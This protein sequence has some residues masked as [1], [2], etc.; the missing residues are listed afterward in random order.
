MK[1]LLKILLA[2]LGVLL[3]LLVM[4]AALTQTRRFR[5]WLRDRIVELSRQKLNGR[6]TL[7]RLEGNLISH[8]E[9]FDLKIEREHET[10]LH[11]P[12]IEFGF[13]AA[14]LWHRRIWINQLIIDRPVIFLRQRPDSSWNVQDLIV[15]DTTAIWPVV[16]P[17]IRI[18]EAE[19][20]VAPRDSTSFFFQRRVQQLN[21]TL[22][23]EYRPAQTVLEVRQLAFVL[24][25]FPL[26]VHHLQAHLEQ[27]AGSIRIEDFHLTCGGS[28]LAGEL[29]VRDFTQPFYRVQLSAAPLQLDDVRALVPAL[30]ARG[31]V[32]LHLNVAGSRDSVHA[33]LDFQH[34]SGEGRLLAHARHAATDTAF[35]LIADLRHA[36]L[37]GLLPGYGPRSD[38]NLS[39]RLAAD[40]LRLDSLHAHLSLEADSSRLADHL[41]S[42]LRLEGS[43]ADN[44]MAASLSLRTP[45]GEISGQGRMADWTRAQRFTADLAVQ[46]LNL[47]AFTSDTTLA[48]DLNFTVN[49]RGEHLHLDSLS[50][51]GSLKLL[52]SQM[53]GIDLA[54]AEAGFQS[55]AGEM[56]LDTLRLQTSAGQFE[57]E[58]RFNRHRVHL[59]HFLVQPGGLEPLRH[60]LAADTLQARGVLGGT[61]QGPFDSLLVHGGFRLSH[62]Q[63]NA[64]GA[65][66]LTGEFT[67]QQADGTGTVQASCRALRLAA[68][69]LDSAKLSA[70][71]DAAA[72]DFAAEVWYNSAGSGVI[73]GRYVFG[74]T[75]RLVVRHAQIDLYDRTWE[76]S[77]DTLAIDLAP[78]TFVFHH[79]ALRSGPEHF[80]LDGRLSLAG[81]ESLRVSVAGLDLARYARFLGLADQVNGILD[82]ETLVSG[83]AQA[84]RLDGHF[85]ISNGRL[86][87]FAYQSWAGT[88]DYQ[89]EKLAWT[90][91]L[92][93][94]SADSLT[95]EG[96]LPLRLRLDGA[97]L[98][99]YRNRPLRMQVDAQ[100]LDL[101]FLQAFTHRIQNL[102]G[103]L[104]CDVE[105]LGT[106]SHPRP[107]GAIR[108]FDGAFRLPANRTN[109]HDLRLTM[110]LQPEVMELPFLE[111]MGDRGKLS[112]SGT[113]RLTENGEIASLA[114]MVHARDFPLSN[115]RVLEL[116]IDT[117]T[118]RL[119]GDA[120]GLRYAG[121]VTIDR[122]IYYLRGIQSGRVLQIDEAE[123][124]PQ[125]AP[126]AQ[127]DKSPWQ[128]LL[129]TIH[130][131]LKIHM[132]RNTW[133]RGPGINLELN[134]EL[135]L[136]QQG[137]DYLLYGAIAIVR[138]TYELYGKKFTVRSGRL[139]FQGDYT[140]AVQIDLLASYVFRHGKERHEMFVKITGALANP[141]I[142]FSLDNDDKAIEQKDA[143]SY[144]LFNVPAQG[145]GIDLTGTAGSVVSGLVSQQLSQSLGQSLKLDVI[146]F[147]SGEELTPGSVL[148]GKYITNELFVSVSQD[149]SS[150]NSADALRVTLE[151][152][153]LRQ[154]FLQ[155]TRGG[156]DEKDTGFDVIWKK[157]W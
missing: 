23:V 53:W 7:G 117:D 122:A 134:G 41:L 9:L 112:A 118:T 92:Q 79:L 89:D 86:A 47:A 137:G 142:A 43:A 141:Q 35:Q 138:G 120:N 11:I 136:V 81:A 116:R 61:V 52:P 97:P 39:L 113:L 24:G 54:A 27:T 121:A 99:V 13:S 73:S 110:S 85:L 2:M 126:P 88:F 72:T 87:K 5:D 77:G 150:F 143:I 71:F 62:V 140:T 4:A 106:L 124:Q 127:T 149:F 108:I 157:E 42:S 94:H 123:L 15:T 125:Q 76:T 144:I 65:N 156:K 91:G 33:A 152:E 67:F 128:R 49:L 129:D 84:P 64:A 145:Y 55:R 151:L 66:S 31:P 19:V 154:F 103:T 10:V 74:D 3:L 14:E 75:A 78:E 146:E 25:D 34:A 29:L 45:M 133:V 100:K 102:H 50:A 26:A 22:L 93:Q 38:L 105:I 109:Y 21:A 96:F 68:A 57:V 95:G 147:G 30:P 63:F 59:L 82:V 28:K 20:N 16:L 1:R 60:F 70:S 130:G 83:T 155:A 58:G 51:G 139:I 8:F 69:A 101:S 56:V 6:L 18:R 17:V 153:I 37:A 44:Q 80:E 90:F 119:H 135:D 115:N 148:V 131:E 114:G 32:E 104:A 107:S 111:V 40:R 132:P 98:Q 36:D 46:R 12:R 48:S